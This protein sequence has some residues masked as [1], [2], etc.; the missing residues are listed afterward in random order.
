VKASFVLA[1][2]CG[3]LATVCKT[4]CPMLSDRCPVCPVLSCPVCSIGLL[5]PNGWTD[6]DETWRAGRPLPWPHC[7]RWEPTSPPQRDTAPN[8]RSISVVAKWL[9]ELKCH[10]VGLS[11][12]DF[13]LDGDL[14]P[15]SPKGDR[16]Q[17]FFRPMFIVE[18]RL[19]GSRWHLVWS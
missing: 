13:V 8:F 4:V 7:V 3:F 2:L 6:Q 9:D 11:P 1:F 18:K 12:H 17:D 5:W 10:L 19:D 15:H 14:A 16:A